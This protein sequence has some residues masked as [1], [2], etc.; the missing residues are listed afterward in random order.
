MASHGPYL[1]IENL[2]RGS[3]GVVDLVVLPGHGR[4]LVLKSLASRLENEGQ[5]QSRHRFAREIM[6]STQL[7]HRCL[8]QTI[9]ADLDADPPYLVSNFIAGVPWKLFLDDPSRLRVPGPIA[10]AMLGDLFE[11]LAYL[12]TAASDERVLMRAHRDV[13]PQN[14]ILGFDGTTRL[15]DLGLAKTNSHTHLTHISSAMGT[16]AYMAPEVAS[17]SHTRVGPATDIY[18]AC[19]MAYELMSGAA[20]RPRQLSMSDMLER[21]KLGTAE[22]PPVTDPADAGVWPI[23][24]R[25]LSHRTMNR[26]ASAEA[27][28]QALAAARPAASA[29]EVAAW[30]E[31]QFPDVVVRQREVVERARAQGL[32]LTRVAGPAEHSAT[33]VVARAS[34]QP[35]RP[36]P[37]AP[38]T[39]VVR[40]RG[41]AA[42]A[43]PVSLGEPGVGLAPVAP[44]AWSE[45]GGADGLSEDSLVMMMKWRKREYFAAA[46]A[47][48]AGL[49]ER[50]RPSRSL[51]RAQAALSELPSPVRLLASKLGAIVATAVVTAFISVAV[52]VRLLGPRAAEP[53]AAA[54]QLAAVDGSV[55][56]EVV[57]ASAGATVGQ[58]EDAGSPVSDARPS[59][60]ATRVEPAR[61]PSARDASG[62][63]ARAVVDGGLVDAAMGR[64]Q[65][66]R[67]RAELRRLREWLGQ[68]E[69][70]DKASFIAA[71]SRLVRDPA[72]P[73]Y[74]PVARTALGEAASLERL[75]R[76]LDIVES[77]A[78]R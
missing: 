29:A 32:A 5:E 73:E 62:T 4:P 50:L 30:L 51:E 55:G 41:A 31:A 18:S 57:V 38:L 71:C 69:P 28:R 23:I 77:C 1:F 66:P 59:R 72:C 15:I 44:L 56:R 2:G 11:V 70:N 76:L 3:Q 45:I 63:V 25:G 13:S 17:A 67:V 43:E 27:V 16:V 68:L 46:D 34:L 6:L 40:V 49:P 8:V 14:L 22:A 47:G 20:F 12:H 61:T 7:S 26:Y 33:R 74:A 35:A 39:A 58:A 78:A 21:A 24:Y 9:D 42:D 36:A 64:T 10:L 48:V 60:D 37:D 75:T 54:G 65:D 53:D 52:T 19:A